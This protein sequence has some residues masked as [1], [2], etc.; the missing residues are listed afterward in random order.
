MNGQISLAAQGLADNQRNG[1]KVVSPGRGRRRRFSR[2]GRWLA[3]ALCLV[4]GFM[5][6]QNAQ[7]AG[8]MTPR[9]GGQALELAEQHVDVTVANGYTVTRVD[10]T[11]R[12][13]HSRNLDARYSF[14][15]PE[16][17]AVGEFTYWIDGLPVHAEVL[18]KTRARQLHEEQKQQGNETALLEKDEYRTFEVEVSPV[19]A[20]VSVRIRLVYLQRAMVD[21]SVGRY[22]YPLEEGGVDEVRDSFWSANN[23]VSENF[24]FKLH[25]RSAY[26]VDAVRVPNGQATV[27][28]LDAG[29]WLVNIDAKAGQGAAIG[30][31]L[32]DVS[33]ESALRADD[34]PIPESQN[35]LGNTSQAHGAQFMQ[36][37]TV[38]P[39]GQN[40]NSAFSLDKDIVVYWRLAENLPGAVDLVTYREPGSRSGTFMLTLTPG[41]D[42]APITEGR[43]WLFVLD[44]SGSMQT[45]FSA[46]VDGVQ[47]AIGAL[48]PTDRFKI[49]LFSDRATS[50]TKGFVAADSSAVGGVLEKLNRLQSGGGTNLF[51]GLYSA[52]KSL[53]T[54][55]TT[56]I[57]LVTDGVA[58]VGH[59]AMNKFLKLMEPVDVRLFTAV[60]GNSANRPLLE[61][62]TKHSEGF[63]VNVS[64]DDD[65][66]GLMLQM[67]SKVTH[68]A[69]H[70]VEVSF[71]GI[72]VSNLTPEKF[73]R[74][75]RGEQL[76]MFGQFTGTG[77][78]KALIKADVSGVQQRY[79]S[80][81]VF[82]T[83]ATDNP[84]L[85]RL[86]AFATIES[87][88]DEQD[89][90]GETEDSRQGIT[91][92]ALSAGIV[93]DYTSLVIVRD[94][95][96]AQEGI[97][98][99][100]AQRTK[101]ENEARTQRANQAIQNTRQDAQA[102]AFPSNRQ[103]VSNGSNSGRSSGSSGGGSAGGWL[104]FALALL[105]SI[106]IGLGV[107]DRMTGRDS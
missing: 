5:G 6:V 9:N 11:F 27:S 95:V 16:K 45:K 63:A 46:M 70:N 37:R 103:T 84:E 44:T 85:E 58:N 8:L 62:L 65:M 49:I 43:D 48:S 3:A 1:G 81:L 106:R 76:V 66:M 97:E 38:T 98:R 89:L 100:N 40:N 75:Y 28:Q 2:T 52:V 12:N 7:A 18:E 55:R 71:E 90:L 53:D 68:E 41:V 96:F 64:N 105:L 101:R 22:V 83:D 50:L 31:R 35:N 34:V 29:E 86:W 47:R 59:T 87:L 88:L 17:A 73:T 13:P 93:T 24:T 69:L 61:S 51:D 15:V 79:V 32:D 19:R 94:E 74:V 104:L 78:A 21:H 91:D 56:A 92:V 30:D 67:T 26:P 14:P 102:P 57:V 36:G 60:M 23:Q 39:A 80:P 10:Q 25:L 107:K 77:N 72:R 82:T 42:L 4:T 54:D 33:I 20:N 99:S